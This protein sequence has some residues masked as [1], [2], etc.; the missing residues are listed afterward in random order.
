LS[1]KNAN[2]DTLKLNLNLD[3]LDKLEELEKLKSPASN[4]TCKEK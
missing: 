3:E 4:R 1:R 2:R